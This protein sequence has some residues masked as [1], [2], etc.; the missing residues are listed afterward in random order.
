MKNIFISRDQNEA[1]S[2]IDNEYAELG[3]E[4]LPKFQG[5]GLMNSALKLILDHTETLNI[6]HIETKTHRDNLKSRKL[7]LRNGFTLLEDVTDDN[8]LDNVVYEYINA[9]NK[10]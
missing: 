4:I 8:N 5:K 3:Y 9:N 10:S 2:V 6:N 7:V 1:T